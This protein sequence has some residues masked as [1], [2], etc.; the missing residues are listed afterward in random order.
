MPLVLGL[1]LRVDFVYA[2]G[3]GLLFGFL[4]QPLSSPMLK[5]TLKKG[6]RP[7]LLL[8]LA[9]VMIFKA[10]LESSGFI[11]ILADLLSGYQTPLAAL[12]FVLPLAIGL[13]TGMELVAV[14]MVYPLLLGLVPPGAPVIPYILIMMT[15]NAIGQT[16]SPVHICMVVGNEY[17]GA[18][19]GK[20]IRMN[21]VPQGFR[22]LITFLLAWILLLYLPR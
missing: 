3:A 6:V 2:M 9:S 10:S 1:A 15:A 5:K 11:K 8:I 12:A 16:H 7:Q 18:G 13:A 20:V 14:G 22:L 21:L 4:T 19:L 17:F